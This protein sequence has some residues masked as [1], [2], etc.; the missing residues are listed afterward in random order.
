MIQLLDD[1]GL[2]ANAHILAALHQQRLIDQVAQRV[3]LT[4]FDR[5][6]QLFRSA[7]TLAILFR[8]V[9][10]RG[11]RLFVFRARNDFVVYARDDLFH[12]AARVGI[13]LRRR[14]WSFLRRSRRGLGR[15]R[16]HSRFFERSESTYLECPQAWAGEC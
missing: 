14:R 15:C 16:S 1:I 13:D 2:H 11:A 8:F 10:S 9:S 12:Y 3:F 7:M 6:L 5:N 4:I